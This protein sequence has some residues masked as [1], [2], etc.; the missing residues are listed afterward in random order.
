MES[1]VDSF[2]VESVS[3]GYH[4]YEKV[5]SSVIEEVL[6]CQ[7]DTQNHHGPFAI[8]TCKGTIVVGHIPRQIS[9]ICYVFLGKPGASITCSVAGSHGYNKVA[10]ELKFVSSSTPC[11][12]HKLGPHR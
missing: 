12:L 10:S 7:R 5:W 4:I 6:V 11:I 2:T 1:E 9:A 8:A 3:G